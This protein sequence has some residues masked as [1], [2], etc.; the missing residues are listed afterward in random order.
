MSTFS[1]R[2]LPPRDNEFCEGDSQTRHL[3][4]ERKLLAR[5]RIIIYRQRGVFGVKVADRT[6]AQSEQSSFLVEDNGTK[7]MGC[8]MRVDVSLIKPVPKRVRVSAR[9]GRIVNILRL[10]LVRGV[11]E[12]QLVQSFRGRESM[13]VRCRRRSWETR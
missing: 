7:M 5:S 8:K 11:Q 1:A 12:D 10:R 4:V 13:C 3:R 6:I 9:K 2:H